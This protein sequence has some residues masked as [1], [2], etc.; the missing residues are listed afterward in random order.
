MIHF[1]LPARPPEGLDEWDP[2]VEPTLHASGTGHN[3]LE[4]YV[5]LRNLGVPVT[6]GPEAATGTRLLVVYSKSLY[7]S[8]PAT[9]LALDSLQHSHGRLALIRSDAPVSWRFPVRPLVEFMPTAAAADRPWQRW[10]PPLPQRGLLPRDP[11]RRGRIRSLAF[12]GNPTNVPAEFLAPDWDRALRA[13]GLEWHLDV[14]QATDGSD[15]SWHDF[16]GVDAVL[17]VRHPDFG[18]DVRRKPATRLVNAWLAGSIPLAEREPGYVELG[19]DGRDVFFISSPLEAVGV[20]DRLNVDPS[21]LA[22]VERRIGERAEEF[23]LEITLERWREA[24]V[25]AA[26]A[27]V[28]VLG[29]ARVY[30]ARAV[31]AVTTPVD[32]YLRRADRRLAPLKRFAARGK[33]R[34]LGRRSRH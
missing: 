31:A 17:C 6:I 20:V 2:D 12:K 25:E 9:R 3:L 27:R 33:R 16:R 15:Q 19:E 34:F 10:L 23:R 8:R 21:R 32:P 1:W 26:G 13:H 5:R 18:W 7:Q 22:E 11:A 30:R 14:P 29:A 4:L 28:A 24:L